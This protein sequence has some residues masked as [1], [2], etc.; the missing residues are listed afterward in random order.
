[1]LK[2]L[3]IEIGTEELPAIPF[4]KEL[5]NVEKKW[6]DILEKNQL[7][8]NF[9]IFY[10][11]RRL[12]LWHREFKIKQD[13]SEV[14]NIGAPKSIAFKD[15]T[16]TPA[17]FSFA[18][19]CGVEVE[20]LE[21]KDFGKGE[22]L[23]H[24]S[25]V[26]GVFIKDILNGMINEFVSSLN[27][28]KSMRWGSRNDSFIRPIRFFSMMLDS[29][30]I[31]GELFGIKSS[32][33]S[34]GHRMDSY[35]P[36]SFSNVGDYFCKL[37]KYGVILYQDERREKILKQ[38]R[39]I[40]TKHNIKVE[41][42]EELLAEV[43]AITEYPTALLGKFDEEFLELPSEVIVTSMKEN[44]RY[45]AVYKNEKLINNFV[46]VSNALTND[47]GYI[48]AGNEKVLRPRLAD[49]MFFYRNDIK[50][51]LKNDG[52]K[53]LVFVEG[54]GTV[55]EKCEREAKIA[56]YLANK[57]SV[58]EKE[59][60]LLEKAVMLSK[61]D[62][63]SEMVYEFT[64]LQGLMGYY[65]SKIEKYDEK[66]S[67]ALKEQYLPVGENSELPTT[68]FSSIVAMSNKIDNLMALFSIGKIPTGSKDPFALRRAALG[69]VKIAIEHKLPIDFKA[70][71][72]DL[73]LEYKNL[74]TK[75]LNEFFIDRLY[76]IFDRVNPT[77]LKAVISSGETNIYNIYKKVE[78][79]NPIVI[80]DNYKE[81][82]T[83]FN[84]VAN[85]VKDVDFSSSLDI[86]ENLFEMDEE[87][88][89]FAKF[90]E[91]KAI[92]FTSFEEE[93]DR[94][95]SLKPELDNFFDKVFVNHENEKIKQNRK[96]LIANI[97]L[98]FKNIADI[99]EIT[100]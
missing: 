31:D 18:K 35:E 12:V 13:D 93:L 8:C 95:F 11:P 6:S 17:A 16:F 23:Y 10:T 92:N 2:P 9:D 59:S 28:G 1:M 14:E 57:L 70:I 94:L 68:I 25:E 77:V 79:L 43:V 7:L 48:I 50:N 85:I 26:S 38:L 51:G 42:D 88:E 99:K 76:K 100:I 49:A 27:F 89:L 98:A 71:F 62:L 72:E 91:I 32:N 24:K 19:K 97:Y 58:E 90:K 67:L 45:F 75:L 39:D 81:Y 46:V 83:T 52:L 33:I 3:L 55:Y 82:S 30:I 37:D 54:L 63:M 80:S 84:R 15:G 60:A 44:Q 56:S 74:D 4:L 34:F 21:F 47:F 87:R 73:K 40:E 65:Y 41:I 69:V 5:P 64:E 53:K 20:E 29:E 78:A 96:N 36:F 61:A 22:V 86:F 66:I